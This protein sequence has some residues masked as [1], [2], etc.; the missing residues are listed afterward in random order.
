[1]RVW[2]WGKQHSRMARVMQKQGQSG[3]VWLGRGKTS[4][5][6]EPLDPGTHSLRLERLGMARTHSRPLVNMFGDH[7]R[8]WEVPFLI[9]GRVS[10]CKPRKVNKQ[11]HQGVDGGRSLVSNLLLFSSSLHPQ[12]QGELSVRSRQ[13]QAL[14]SALEPATP[15]GHLGKCCT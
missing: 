4:G 1:M 15:L 8:N 10:H 2:E 13:A 7:H 14:F 5:H 11:E 9:P 6:R 3:G 12:F